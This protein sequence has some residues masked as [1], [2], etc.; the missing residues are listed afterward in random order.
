MDTIT[1]I[2]LLEFSLFITIMTAG[3]FAA[4]RHHKAQANL[5]KIKKK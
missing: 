4:I 3:G 5:S 2:A 1:I